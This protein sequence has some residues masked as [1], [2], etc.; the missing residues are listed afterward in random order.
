MD[1]GT[2]LGPFT[3]TGILQD[4][5]VPTTQPLTQGMY[6]ELL[7]YSERPPR[8]FSLLQV[9]NMNGSSVDARKQRDQNKLIRKSESSPDP[10]KSTEKPVVLMKPRKPGTRGQGWDPG[11]QRLS[12]HPFPHGQPYSGYSR[13]RLWQDSHPRTRCSK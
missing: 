9:G 8:K 2:T 6:H 13:T 11:G 4:N 3:T 10:S 7:S 12:E 1:T 5:H